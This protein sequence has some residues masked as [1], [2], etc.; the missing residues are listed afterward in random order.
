MKNKSYSTTGRRIELKDVFTTNDLPSI[1]KSIK[2]S[3]FSFYKPYPSR[4]VNSIYFDDLL[5]T[6]LE[7]SIE[8]NSIRT[9]KRLRWYGDLL[10]KS[11]AVLEFKKKL[12]TYSWKELYTNIYC[13]NPIANEW[14]NFILPQNNDNTLPLKKLSDIPVSIVTYNR[15]YYNSFDDKVRITIDRNMKTYKQTNLHRPNITFHQNH[16]QTIVLEVKVSSENSSLIRVACKD[17]PFNPQ[18][19][20]KY[21]ESLITRKS[22]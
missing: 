13:I 19:F 12:G 14:S 5:H 2:L 17:I 22:L 7:E 21:C 6:S 4:R 9:K 11:N 18:R 16:Q 1:E 15:E 10:K 3:N 8:G 20:S